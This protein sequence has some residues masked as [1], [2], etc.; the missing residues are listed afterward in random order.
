MTVRLAP[1]S[2]GAV[3]LSSALIELAGKLARHPGLTGVH[4]LRHET[5]AISQTTEQKIRGTPDDV[6]DFVLLATAYER[7]PLGALEAGLLADKALQEMGASADSVTRGI[8]SISHSA[9]PTDVR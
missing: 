5:P 9:V 3:R 7:G 6:A 2:D 1:V 4:L 8:Y